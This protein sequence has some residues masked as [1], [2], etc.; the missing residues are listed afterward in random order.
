MFALLLIRW[1]GL[2][3]VVFAG[4]IGSIRVRPNHDGELSTLL[5]QRCDVPCWHSIYPGLT[6]GQEALTLVR[7]ISHV[8]GLGSR[9]DSYYGQ[10]FWRWTEDSAQF[11]DPQIREHAYIWLERNVVENVFLPGFHAFGDL[12]LL[13]G[14]P[15]RVVIYTDSFYTSYYVVYLAIYPGEFYLSSLLTCASTMRDLLVSPT[16]I[17]IGRQ[18]TYVGLSGQAYQRSE[19]LGWLPPQLCS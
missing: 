1:G 7:Q 10:I 5:G 4:L 2:I 16:D 9:L 17:Y 13:M 8:R 18:P 3:S 19:L 12:A 11:L 15:Q 14:R 6:T